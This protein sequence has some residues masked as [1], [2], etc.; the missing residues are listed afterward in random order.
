MEVTQSKISVF[1]YAALSFFTSMMLMPK[2][3][4]S[5]DKQGFLDSAFYSVKRQYV[6]MIGSLDTYAKYP[7][8]IDKDNTLKFDSGS[9]WTGGFWPGALW[10]VYEYSGDPLFR[11]EA[12]KFTETL[13]RNQ[14]NTKHH[15]V[16]FVMYSSYGN[17]YR[18]TNAPEYKKVLIQSAESLSSRYSPVVGSIQ[19]WNSKRSWDGET[20]WHF[21]VIID[22]LMNLELL[23]FASK[24]TGNAKYRN[25]AIKHAETTMRNHIRSDYSSFHVVNYD[26]KTGEVLSKET[27]QGFS[28]NSTWARGQAWGI[29]GFTMVYRETGDKRF[30]KTAQKMAD[31]Y[32]NHKNLPSDKI[33]YWDFNVN[34]VGYLPKW[35]YDPLKYAIK[36]K[37]AS[38]ASIV[39]SALFELG[40]Y[41]GKNGQ[42]YINEAIK[43]LYSLRSEAYFNKK[44]E[45]HNF[46]LDHAVGNFPRGSEID[47]PIIYADY[48]FLEA[49]LRYKKSKF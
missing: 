46:L 38:A 14:F 4:L 35:P 36:P 3:L 1:L 40:D 32:L 13:S 47:V 44:N 31:F 39:A 7:R 11:K 9:D 5:Q 48:Y 16:G 17:A 28:D 29:Y 15:D 6:E 22:N 8:S 20:V 27:A 26:V 18:L 12:L 49:L 10:F 43:I 21:P 42:Q 2:S 37:D 30:L 24:V 45:K 34:Q 33:P 23:F 41:S 19:S 25:I